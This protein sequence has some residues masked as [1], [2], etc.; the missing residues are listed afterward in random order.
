LFIGEGAKAVARIY[1]SVGS[2]L[3]DAQEAFVQ[4]L[5]AR[6]AAAGMS[7]HTVGRNEFSSDA[8][9]IAVRS[10]MESCD[11]VIVLAL[12]RLRFPEGTER[13]GSSREQKL[14]PTS[15]PTSWNQIEASLAYEKGLPLLVIVDEAVRQDGMLEAQYDWYVETL[16]TRPD[17]LDSK[18]FT[19]RLKH[20]GDKIKARAQA[21]KPAN[22]TKSSNDL[23]TTSIGEWLRLLTP[24][25]L[26]AI[27]TPVAAAIAT[28]FG[29]GLWLGGLE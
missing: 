28:S 29:F 21:P 12:E 25:Q 17:E 3:S 16:R 9:L 27:L 20:F 13:P 2:G 8:P 5:E 7:T 10:L 15:L 19:A 22:G 6:I 11:G 1:L 14:G 18:Q 23:E 26:W 24:G 4:S